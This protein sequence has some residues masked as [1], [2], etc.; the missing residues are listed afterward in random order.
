MENK[1]KILFVCLFS[2]ALFSCSSTLVDEDDASAPLAYNEGYLGIIFDT[3]DPMRNI[4]I[5]QSQGLLS[6]QI[7][8]RKK[9]ISLMLLRVKEGEYCFESFDVY[10]LEVTYNDKGFCT[11]VEAGEMNYFGDFIVRSPVSYQRSYYSRFV[12]FVNDEYPQIC[13]EYI[14]EPCQ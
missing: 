12:R 13:K 1:I 10:N 14:G 9:G 8:G 3:L 2:L 6:M 5:R 11:Y 4:K 7:G